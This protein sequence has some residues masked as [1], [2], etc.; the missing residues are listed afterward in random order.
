MMTL[1]TS[2]QNERG[3]TLVELMIALLIGLILLAGVSS[4]FVSSKRSYTSNDSLAR[5]QENA[6]I[7]MQILTRTLRST[8]YYGCAD[9]IKSVN[10]V[11]NPGSGYQFNIGA[12]LE[13]ATYTGTGTKW[14]PSGATVDLP[15]KLGTDVITTRFLDGST[16]IEMVSEMNQSAA[17]MKIN[18]GS[19]I[20]DGDIMML[21][22]CSSA[23]VFQV[24]GMQTKT[25]FDHILHNAGATKPGNSTQKLSKPYKEDAKLMK[26]AAVSFFVGTGTDGEPA[27]FRH[28]LVTNAS[29]VPTMQTQE[30]IQGVENFQILY[31]ETLDGDRVPDTYVKASSVSDWNNVVS[32]K[33]G[34]L[35]R[36]LANLETTDKKTANKNLDSTKYDIDGDGANDYDAATDTGTTNGTQNRLYDRRVFRTN[37][38]LRNLQ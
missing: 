33:F 10:S 9:D 38:L 22:D 13:G 11:I 1:K 17:E 24:T 2:M 12:R 8:G 31:G 36:S 30:L 29:G 25:G 20:Q 21:T 26:F 23:D 28:T 16:A 27:L 7:T 18:V 14:L 19:G 3:F 37:I 35:A 32:M 34:I 5:L 15:A 6:R 4:V